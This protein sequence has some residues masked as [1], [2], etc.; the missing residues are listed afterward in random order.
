[1][2][3]TKRDPHKEC[4][5]A[6]WTHDLCADDQNSRRKTGD[7]MTDMEAAKE[8]A[9][10]VAAL[11]G[12]AYFVGGCVRDRLLQRTSKDIDIEIHGISAD[13]LE[14]LLK[15]LG[16]CLQMGKSFGI[17]GLKGCTLDIALPRRERPTGIGHRDF[18]VHADPFL[19]TYEAARR[20]DF[21][22]NALME[23]V[24]TG[25]ILDHFGGQADLEKRILRHIDD[26]TF[27]EDPLRVLRAA[28]F[29]ARFHF[30]IAPETVALCR[31]MNLSALSKARIFLEMEKALLRADMPSICFE[32]LRTMEQLDFWFPELQALIGVPQHAVHHQE[33]D[34]WTHTMMVLDEAAKRR[35]TVTYPLGFMLSALCHD[36]G[37]A[38]C[39]A[40]VDGVIHAYGHELEGLPLVQQFLTRLT[41][42]TK[43]VQY[44]LNMTKLHMQPGAMA[45]A[46]TRLKSTN[47]LFDQA[48]APFDL[49]Q[50]S[51]CDGLGKM[52]PRTDTEPFLLQRYAQF[53]EIMEKPYVTGKDLV[54]AGLKPCQQF[55]EILAYAHK[56]RL[57]GV[58]KE[59]AL[60]QSLAYARKEWRI[61]PDETA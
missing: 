16:G 32:T 48:I 14:R 11:D 27:P 44:V 9:E 30:S 60:K 12:T 42:E 45:G 53:I 54:A 55:S 23:N 10:R 19:G 33:G 25:E 52:P 43:L 7:I 13:A 17:Y 20:R 36:F 4:L 8:I 34:T 51:I 6:Y 38:V 58:K 57:A 39:T 47:R 49:I 35:D 46:H 1:M 61:Y 59:S 28:Q 26:V 3:V 40:E 31:Q 22:I 56:L 2:G 50:L 37:K 18:A 21:T 5:A 24:L 29:A 41:S 15:Q